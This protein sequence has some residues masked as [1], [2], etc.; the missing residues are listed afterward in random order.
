MLL[1]NR[2]STEAGSILSHADIFPSQLNL[3]L[4]YGIALSNCTNNFIFAMESRKLFYLIFA[5]SYFS[6]IRSSIYL[7]VAR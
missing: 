5:F 2:W 7:A 6:S 1:L 3:L 4:F